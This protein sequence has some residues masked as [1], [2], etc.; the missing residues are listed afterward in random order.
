MTAQANDNVNDTVIR[1][2]RLIL[3]ELGDR[4]ED[5]LSYRDE[6]AVRTAVAKAC[7]AGF[8][9]GT[10]SVLFEVTEAAR[11]AGVEFNFTIDH[12]PGFDEW[13]LEFEDG[14]DDRD[15]VEA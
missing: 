9:A 1:R 10:G 6:I 2:Y 11:E 4:L 8:H 3:E 5:D 15:G 12:K 14:D 13:A 7:E